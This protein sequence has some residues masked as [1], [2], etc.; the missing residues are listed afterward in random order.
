MAIQGLS[1]T[2]GT[3]ATALSLAS[4]FSDTVNYN[5]R[6]QSVMVQNPSS[7]VSVYIGGSNVTSSV[8]GHVLAPTQTFTIDLDGG[9]NIYA[10]V[11]SGTL[12]V[13]VIRK[14]V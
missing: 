3:T 2:V 14:G 4:G 9:E 10:A 7:T 11:A 8:Y 12:A 5:Q 6:G 1:V 13:N